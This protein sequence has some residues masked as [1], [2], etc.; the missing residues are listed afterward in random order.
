MDVIY[1]GSPMLLYAEPELLKLLLVPVLAYAHNDTFIRFSNPY[2][3]HQL[4]TYPIAND[5]TA[6][7]EPMPL[8]N[9]GNMLFMLLGLV[10]RGV[11]ASFIAPYF[12]MLASWADELVR[13]TEYPANQ[14]CTDD[15]TGPL[16]NN[17][18]LG[19]KGIVALEAFAQI[20]KTPGAGNAAGK[21]DCQHYSD[22]A[23]TYAQ[24]WIAHARVQTPRPHTKMSFGPVKGVDD[25]WSLKYNMLWQKMLGLDGP[26]PWEQIVPD[27]IAY[28]KSKA[29]A[30]GI[31]MD[32]RHTYVKTDWLSWAAAMASTVDRTGKDEDFHFIMDPIFKFCNETPSRNPFTDLYATDTGVQ[33]MGG[34]IARP[35]I[36]GLF[37]RMLLD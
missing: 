23:A 29:N 25:S 4:G 27:E 3:P 8:E 14:I 12:A 30:F 31:P 26:F 21:V 17:T 11:D 35:V 15:F 37:A 19:A 6:Q 34:F 16:A 7:Q 33:S 18:N 24:T 20:C 2:S 28:Y 32:P 36:G 5:T 13:T 10:R 1:P 9:S 22:T